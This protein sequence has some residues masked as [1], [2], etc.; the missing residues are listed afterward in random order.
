MDDKKKKLG[1]FY[2]TNYDYILKNFTIPNYVKTI[3]EPFAG[4]CDLL[5]FIK[6][7]K[8]YSIELYDIDPKTNNTIKQDTLLNPPSYENKFLLTNPP[9]LARNK[10]NNKDIFDK[11][12]QNDL[13]KCVLKELCTNKALGGIIIIPLN[14]WSSIRLNDINLRKDFLK[15]YDIICVNIFEEQ[16]FTDTS[17]T[18]CA[19]QFELKNNNNNNNNSN[20][21]NIHIY[22]SERIIN[23]DLNDANNYIIG[24]EIYNLKNNNNYKIT[25]CTNANKDKL[26]TNILAKCIDDNSKSKINLSF[27][28]KK[29]LYID[30]T[31]NQT[32]RTYASLIIEPSID[33]DKQKLLINKFNN[34]LELNRNKYNS[35][36]LT[37]YR[38]SKDI[39]RKRISFDLIYNICY[40]ILDQIDDELNKNIVEDED[41]DEKPKKKLI[42][43]IK[44]SNSDDKKI[45]NN[46]DVKDLDDV[47]D[48]DVVDDEKPKKKTKSKTKSK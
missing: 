24:G 40:M 19:F 23:V 38:E 31:P 30:S 16:V 47:K 9:Y 33:I 15:V 1:Q 21:F 14:F 7:K 42:K 5:N 3:I 26:N 20:N 17:Y 10:S 44:K 8:L 11:Y 22:P 12:N 39:A 6:N 36:F 34:Y 25:R 35:L 41:V 43:K 27:V 4:N 29:D 46:D 18:V 45:N 48:V 37:N 2:T 13:Y 28:D 32:A